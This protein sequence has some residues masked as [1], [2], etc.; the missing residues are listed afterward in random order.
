MLRVSRSV[1]QAAENEATFRAA[2]ETLEQK[3]AELG[4]AGERTP[5]LCECEDPS[6]TSIL[7]LSR[8]DYEA[9]RAHPKRFVMVPGHQEPD[10]RLV[11]EKATYTVI[12]KVGEEG[13]LVAEQNPR[14][15][16][17]RD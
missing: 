6:C 17:A 7:Q 4:F 15:R 5:Y 10:D 9:V 13:E 8:A 14:S 16:N 12:E 3:A 1:Q 11:E 2:N